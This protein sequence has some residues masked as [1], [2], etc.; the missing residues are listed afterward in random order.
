MKDREIQK[1]N[2]NVTGER[3]ETTRRNITNKS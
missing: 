2:E 1:S 3:T